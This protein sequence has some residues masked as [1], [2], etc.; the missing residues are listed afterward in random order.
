MQRL[1]KPTLI[2]LTCA[3]GLMALAGFAARPQ[4]DVPDPQKKEPGDKK[5]EKKGD[6]LKP[7]TPSNEVIQSFP[8]KGPMETAWKIHWA[9]KRGNGLYIQDAFFKKSPQDDWMQVLG[10]ARLAEMFVPYHRGSPRFWDVSF[11]FGMTIVTQADAGPYG[12]LLGGDN[13]KQPNV[14]ME[15]KDRGLMYMSSGGARRGEKLV[16]FGTLLAANYRYTVEYGFQ[17][18]GTVSFRVGSSGINYG[19]SEFVGHMHNGL[20][21]IDVNLDGPDNNSVYLVEHIEPDGR[22]KAKARTELTPFNGGKEGFADFVPEKF[23]MLRVI[24]DKRRNVRGEPLAYDLMPMRAGNARHFGG[25]R[26]VIKKDKDKI[27]EGYTK[28]ECTQH[29]FW[30]TR[31]NNKELI[32]N[33][34]PKYIKNGEGIMKTDV[35]LWHSTAMHHEPRSEDGQMIN[36]RFRGTTLIGWSGFELRPRNLFDR[37]PFFDYSKK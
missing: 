23:T 1:N 3:V 18:D 37:T 11:D 10:D 33:D 30:V 19:G 27:E 29:D 9:T 28:E 21:R 22:D 16:L 36:G 4:A 35:V 7:A 32:Y 2:V 17:D 12:K 26:K 13:G 6:P 34:L 24:N 31:A 8:S 20:W 15:L 5:G 25:E 14:V